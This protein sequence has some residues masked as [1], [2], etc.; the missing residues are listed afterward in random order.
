MKAFRTRFIPLFYKRGI[1][2]TRDRD[3]YR[4]IFK[5]AIPS[6]FQSLIT[7]L[8]VLVDNMM[9]SHLGGGENSF[10]L[11]AVS[12]VNSITAFYTAT[13][14][15][16]VGGS[17]VLISQYWGKRDM[18]RI[19]RVFSIVMMICVSL[20][21]LVVLAARLFPTQILSLVIKRTEADVFPLAQKYFALVCLSYLPY[22]LSNSLVGMLK[23]VEVVRVTLYI[24]IVSLF[25]N[26]FF[27]YVLIFGH[28][29]FPALGVEGAAIATIIARVVEMIVVWF[30][31]FRVQKQLDIRPRDL[32][33]ADRSLLKDY[34]HYGLPVGVVDMQWSFIGMLK[35]AIIGQLGSS[36]MAAVNI[37]DSMMQLGTLFTFA[38]AGG[39][40]VVVGKT[41]G[42]GHIDKAKEYSVTIQ[43]MFAV[44]GVVMAALVILLRAPFISL[45]GPG[46]EEASLATTMIVLGAITM[47]GTSYHAACFVGIN[48]GA[49]DSRFVAMVDMICGWLVVL[50][51]TL[52][53]AFV[54]KLPLPYVYLA[55]RIDQCFKWIIAFKRLR[56]DKWIHNVTQA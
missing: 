5:I 54:L 15:G 45:Y 42:A 46:A 18:E 28:F 3:F 17:A 21:V 13:L 36:F 26:I 4:T 20:S 31:T 40:C 55:T 43:I 9:V 12:Q 33:K 51:C 30:Y 8:V 32:M 7:L 49:G 56:T 50:P 44:L 23:S 19:K 37:A 11:A 27:N 47:I 48:R 35:A 29:G 41:V 52:L 2:V 38:L 16:L 39:A 34:A 10:A 1:L 6:A 25:T 53:A 14:M 24:A 22:A